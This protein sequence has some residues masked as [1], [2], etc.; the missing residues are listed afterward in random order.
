M[1]HI[2]SFEKLEAWKDARD[3][4]VWIY[5]VTTEFPADEKFGL[6]LQLRRASVSVV[7]NLAEGSARK[8]AKDQAYFTQIAYSSLIEVLNQLIISND[9]RFLSTENLEY[10]RTR[11]EN[12]SIKIAALRKFQKFTNLNPKRLNT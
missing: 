4:V 7:S 6:M 10:G 8:T 2:Y 12:L 5:K 9:L 11:M 3:L 1:A